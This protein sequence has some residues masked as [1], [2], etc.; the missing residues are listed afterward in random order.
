MLAPPSPLQDCGVSARHNKFGTFQVK[1]DQKTKTRTKTQEPKTI[2]IKQKN[3]ATLADQM[4]TAGQRAVHFRTLAIIGVAAACG[5]QVPV[6]YPR[7][8]L[9]L[10]TL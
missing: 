5:L 10:H 2:K 9:H 7:C 4:P 8:M 6:S 3:E 1:I